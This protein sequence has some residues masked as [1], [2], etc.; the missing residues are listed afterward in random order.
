MNVAVSY[1]TAL[2]FALLVHAIVIGL[3][4]INWEDTTVSYEDVTPYYIEAAIVAENPYT[5]KKQR[6][7]NRE[8]SSRQKKIDQRRQEERN[9]RRQQA[10]LNEEQRKAL[11]AKALEAVVETEPEP[12]L[13]PTE[14]DKTQPIDQERIRSE[15]EQGLSLALIEEE[16]MRKAVTDDEVAMAYVGQIQREIIQNWSRPPSARNGMKSLLR[17][18]LIPT[19]EVIDVKL[20]DSS[21][22]DAF[23]RSAVLAVRKAGR[24]Q[25]PTDVK[26]FE[27]DFREFTVLFRPDDLRL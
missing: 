21:G 6:T 5:A 16:N 23:D 2:L 3:I 4:S 22:N 20:E 25:V 9:F 14:E 8:K 24:F 1:I 10:R 27:R 7:E 19:G 13:V 12:E 17:V 15:F 18:I 11:A 26:R